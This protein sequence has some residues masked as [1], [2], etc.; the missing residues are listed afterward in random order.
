MKKTTHIFDLMK[1]PSYINVKI[2]ERIICSKMNLLLMVYKI[3]HTGISSRVKYLLSQYTSK[4]NTC[5][6]SCLA[7]YLGFLQPNGKNIIVRKGGVC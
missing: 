6:S 3:D 1:Q 4:T 5:K 7:R 2:S